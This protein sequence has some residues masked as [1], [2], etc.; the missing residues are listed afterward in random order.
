MSELCR[1]S[2]DSTLDLTGADC[3][4]LTQNLIIKAVSI[5][6]GENQSGWEDD[7]FTRNG[8]ECKITGYQQNM[9]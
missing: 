1:S 5:D 4:S 8:N 6:L 2:A 3:N 9:P 7:V